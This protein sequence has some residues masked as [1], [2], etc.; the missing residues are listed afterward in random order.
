MGALT[1]ILAQHTLI[2]LDTSPFIFFFEKHPRYFPTVKELFE[3][4]Q[5]RANL[6]ACTSVVTLIEVCVLPLR[7]GR[8]DL[9]R[10]YERALLASRK[11]RTLDITPYLAMEAAKLRARYNIRVPDAIQV[12]AAILGGAT[13]FVTNDKIFHRIKE[14]QVLLLSDLT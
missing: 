10:T 9:V 1:D 11:I 7:E 5:K 3:A 14:I 2:A 6:Y 13:L 12:A 8:L 4:L